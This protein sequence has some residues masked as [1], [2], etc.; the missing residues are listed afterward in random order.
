MIQIYVFLFQF[1]SELYIKKMS[2]S[3]LY[4]KNAI[5]MRSHLMKSI[6]CL[7]LLLF[8][9]TLLGQGTDFFGFPKKKETPPEVKLAP[10]PTKPKALPKPKAKKKTIT[11]PV[12]Q[13]SILDVLFLLD[14]SGSMD[15]MVPQAKVSKLDA[16]KDALSFIAQKMKSGTRFQLWSFNARM[17]QHPNSPALKPI[18]KQV[19]FESIGA[20]NSIVR[21]HLLKTIESL[22]TRG[23]TNLYKTIYKAIRYFRTSAYQ[24]PQGAKRIKMIVVLADGQDDG[25][26]AIKLNHVLSEKQN[27]ADIKI[28]TI[29]FG[30]Q[31]NDPLHQILCQIASSNKGCTVVSDA[32]TLKTIIKTY[33]DF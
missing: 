13:K 2:I 18:S 6:L 9:L 8:P 27:H 3:N 25:Y 30:I 5:I 24:V 23:G 33:T 17:K 28:R 10:T 7:T 1:N 22:E 20:R 32:S 26:S 15:A 21:K 11:A 4:I 29:G 19:V 14:T 12:V 16:A 31:N